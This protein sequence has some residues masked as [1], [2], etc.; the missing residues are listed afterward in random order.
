M[1]RS[2]DLQKRIVKN[3]GIVWGSVAVVIF[4]WLLAT[5]QTLSSQQ[6]SNTQLVGWT[7]LPFIEV[8]KQAIDG[9]YQASFVFLPGLAWVFGIASVITI[10]T[11]IMQNNNLRNTLKKV[12]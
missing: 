7:R 3:L 12:N 11:V 5:A 10:G 9:G 8:S 6:G 1:L 2:S 4:F